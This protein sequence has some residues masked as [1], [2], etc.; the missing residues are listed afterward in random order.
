MPPAVAEALGATAASVY[1]LLHPRRRCVVVDNL[2]PV[3]EGDTARARAC[4]YRLFRQ[5]GRKLAALLRHESGAPMRYAPAEWSGWQHLDGALKRRQGILLVTLHLGDWE[6][7]GALLARLGL[8]LVIL[9]QAEPGNGFTELRQVARRREGI[10]TV[11]VGS[12]PFAF[13]EVIRRLQEGALVA[14]LIDRPQPAGTVEVTLFDRPFRAS[15]AAADLARATGCCLL[16]VYVVRTAD[17]CAAHML[18]EIPYDRPGLGN[19][20]SRRGLTG[21]ILRA[22]EPVIRQYPDQWYHFIP[23]WPEVPSDHGP[24]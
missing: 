5:F 23:I 1:A 3:L 6:F 18:P 21:Q 17:G 16:P 13:I 11:V 7:G 2:L 4:A 24:G 8:P 12:D 20:E 9:T 14:L 22:F 19:R 10:D 15:V